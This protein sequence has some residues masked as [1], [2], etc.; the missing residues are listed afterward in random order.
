MNIVKKQ[1]YHP[2]VLLAFYLDILPPDVAF[3]IPKTTLYDW[4]NKETKKY[5]GYE[6]YMQNLS[7]FDTLKAVS[8]SKRLIQVNKA[9]L[10]IIALQQFI[11]NYAVQ[12]NQQV[13]NAAKTAVNNIQKIAAVFGAA[14]TLKA[15]NITTYQYRK[16]IRQNKCA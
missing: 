11:R 16:M 8:V 6:W 2:F 12:I 13:F 15:L 5:F 10:K 3:L 14:F 7:F 1:S 4:K 9:L